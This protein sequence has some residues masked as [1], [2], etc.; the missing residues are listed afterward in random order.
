LTKAGIPVAPWRSRHA[1]RPVRARADLG[2][3]FIL[4]TTRLGY[5]GKGQSRIH[6]DE[7]MQP[8]FDTLASIPWSRKA[9]WISPA[10]SA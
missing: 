1:S 5:D 10:K 3:P 6:R 8:A 2:L 7:D 9:W 4:K